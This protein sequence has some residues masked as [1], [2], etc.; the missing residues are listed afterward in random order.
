MYIATDMRTFSVVEDTGF[1]DILKAF[2][3]RYKLP[4]RRTLKNF[5]M[6]FNPKYSEENTD[7]LEYW[8]VTIPI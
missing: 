8:K 3:P 5:V 4:S 6:L 7:P 2:D 1:R